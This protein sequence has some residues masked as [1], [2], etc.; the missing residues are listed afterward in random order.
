MTVCTK[1]IGCGEVEIEV[2]FFGAEEICCVREFGEPIT[3]SSAE[4]KWLAGMVLRI[5]G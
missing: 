2:G 5:L 4:K 1:S 3:Y